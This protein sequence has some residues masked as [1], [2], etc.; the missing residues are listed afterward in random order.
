MGLP[1]LGTSPKQIPS[2]S[3]TQ[4][5]KDLGNL[6]CTRRTVCSVRADHLQ[7]GH[8]PSVGRGRLSEIT[9]RTTSDALRKT[10]RP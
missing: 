1:T 8:R 6:Q 2:E 5:A 9:A 3:A 7:G 10:D 4:E